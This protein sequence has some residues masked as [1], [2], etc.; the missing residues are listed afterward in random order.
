MLSVFQYAGQ[1]ALVEMDHLLIILPD[2]MDQIY[3]GSGRGVKYFDFF[4][5]PF[6]ID[7]SNIE[8]N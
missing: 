6:G 7:F 3:I 2:L 5:L 4:L 8:R 1:S